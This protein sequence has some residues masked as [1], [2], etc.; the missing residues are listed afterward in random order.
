VSQGKLLC[1]GMRVLGV[2]VSLALLSG[3]VGS[4]NEAASLGGMMAEVFD[5]FAPWGALYGAYV[6]HSFG[7]QDVEVP[8]G[9]VTACQQAGSHVAG[10]HI[11]LME[12]T[13]ARTVRTWIGVARLRADTSAFCETHRETLEALLRTPVPEDSLLKEAAQHGLFSEIRA[14][15]QSL[16][17]VLEAVMETLE[18]ERDRWSFGAAFA[19]RTVLLQEP[20][21][22]V[23][24][25]LRAILYGSEEAETPPTFVRDEIA[26]AI[27]RLVPW[28]GTDLTVDTEE[29]VRSMARFLFDEVLKGI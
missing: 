17:D 10:L 21:E 12:Q 25:E 2:V 28:V 5:A 3:V 18:D 27:E 13:G 7:G 24:E 29:K 6:Q 11:R 20:L 14:L 19:L 4:G 26:E 8:A 16:E 1:C 15:Q 22:R 23:G 9:V